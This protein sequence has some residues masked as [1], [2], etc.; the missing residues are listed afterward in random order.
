MRIGKASMADPKIVICER[1]RRTKKKNM[2]GIIYVCMN[3]KWVTDT[4]RLLNTLLDHLPNRMRA[5]KL[6]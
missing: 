6:N 1:F 5:I 3:V 2:M 4:L